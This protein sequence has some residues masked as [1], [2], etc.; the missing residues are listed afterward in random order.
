MF[1]PFQVS[2]LETP[3]PIPCPPAS[4]RV[5]FIHPLASSCP[6]IPIH[7]GIKHPQAWGPLLPL[8]SNKAILCHICGQRHGLLHVYSLV[9][10]PVPGSSVGSG[11]LTLLLPLWGYKPPQLLHSLLYLLHRE[12]LSSVQWLAVSFPP[13][14]V[15]LWKSLLGDSLLLAITSIQSGF[16]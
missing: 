10:G 14:F 11:L 9:V 8:M 1:P 15:R 16:Y 12:P 5:L 6:A 13:V 4:M 3:Y 7:W 2:P